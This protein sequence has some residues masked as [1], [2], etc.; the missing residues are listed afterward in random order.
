[1]RRIAPSAASGL[2]ADRQR[3]HML[4][5]ADQHPARLLPRHHVRGVLE[6]DPA[7]ER[8]IHLIQPCRSRRGWRGVV[9]PAHEHHDRNRELMHAREVDPQELGQDPAEGKHI[10]FIDGA[11]GRTIVGRRQQPGAK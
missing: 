9:M 10:A 11:P 4:E 5:Q 1:M 7:L 6:P 8:G 2:R 3:P